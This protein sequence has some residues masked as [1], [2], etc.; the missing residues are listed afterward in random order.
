MT[1]AP[2]GPVVDRAVLVVAVVALVAVLLVLAVA[3]LS[4]RW[5]QRRAAAGRAQRVAPGRPLLVALAAGDD[6]DGTL[7]DRLATLPRAQWRA[8]EPVAVAMLGKVRG[9][10]RT[11]L[12]ALLERRGVVQRA[13]RDARH[14]RSTTR[15]RAAHLLGLVGGPGATPR[16]AALLGDRDPEVRAV[17]ARSLGRLG[18]PSAATPLVR[19]L[20]RARPLPHQ[21]VV[22]ALARI[23]PASRTALLAAADH[24]DPTV[25]ARVIEALGLVGA[26]DTAPRLVRAL[27]EDPAV[28]VRLR[29]ARALGRLGAPSAVG[30]LLAATGPDEPTALRVTAAQ[31]LG[32]LGARR[33][34][35]VLAGLV[36][37]PHHWVAH[38]AAAALVAVGPDGA[39]ALRGLADAAPG[40]GADRPASAHAREALAAAPG[41]AAA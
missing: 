9:D 3:L 12:V 5:W 14:R 23:G 38:T 31:A 17:T 21:V 7:L 34:I 30:P 11:A 15:A 19:A 29:A 37:D 1:A 36:A 28:D 41:A 27:G 26:V 8:L 24:H 10:A 32:V 4:G 13:L 22:P 2:A 20:V 6:D 35:P 39:A 18:D 40:G 33:A 25:R 16:L